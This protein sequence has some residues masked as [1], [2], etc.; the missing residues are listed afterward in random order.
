[1][2]DILKND[3]I[4]LIAAGSEIVLKKPGVYRFDLSDPTQARMRVFNGQAE[5]RRAGSFEMVSA[6][7]GQAVT[8]DDGL[9]VRKFNLKDM[10]ALQ[11]WAAARTRIL[12]PRPF[13][14]RPQ[15]PRIGLPNPDPLTR[16]SSDTFSF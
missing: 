10:D 7:R 13:G 8:L 1:V 3:R 5:V 14:L 12:L 11:V 6:K 4:R 9:E 2:N 16:L 15:P